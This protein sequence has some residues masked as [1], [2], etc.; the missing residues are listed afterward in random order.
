MYYVYSM[1]VTKRFQLPVSLFAAS[2]AAVLVGAMF[3]TWEMPSAHALPGSSIP[4]AEDA[5]MADGDALVPDHSFESGLASWSL[6]DGYGNAATASCRSALSTTEEWSSDGESSLLIGDERRCHQAGVLSEAVPIESGE[7]YTTWA[8]VHDGSIAWL[9]VHWI[10]ENGDAL[11]EEHSPR[12]ARDDRLEL[13]A[14]APEGA[15]ALRVEIGAIGGLKVDN[16]LLSAQY[17][18]LGSQVTQRPR[19]LSAAAGVDENGRDVLWGMATGSEDDPGILIATDLLTGEVTRTVRLPGATGGWEVTQNPVTGTVY[20]G[21]YG[22]GALWLYTPGDEEAVDAGAPDIPQWDFAYGVAFDE[23][24]NAYGGGW[25]EPTKGY[26]GA[27]VYTFTE[28]EGFTGA[29][30]TVPLTDEANYTRAVG[31]DE[32]SRT[33]FVGT[34]TQVNL[35]GCSIDTNDCED[36][37]G[38]LDEEIQDSVEVREMVVSDGHVLAWVGDGGSTGNDWVVVLKVDRTEAGELQVDVVDEIRGAAYPGSSP[39]VDGHI[40]YTKAGFDGW[41]LFSYDIEAGQETQLPVDA[42]ALVRQWDVVELDDPEWPG[43]TVVGIDSFGTLVRYSIETERI[44]VAMVP[45]FPDVSLRL[46]SLALGPDGS[47]W[48]SGYLNGGIGQ[49]VPMRDDQQGTFP[50]G[51]QAEEMIAHDGRVFQGVYPSGT[52]TSFTP[53]QLQD[54]GA[55]TV[56]CEIGSGQ[57]RPYGMF[58]T[59]D[60]LYFGSQAGAQGN[61]GAFGWVDSVTGECSTLDGPIGEQSIDALTGSNDRIFGGGNIFYGYLHTPVRDE[62]SVMVFDESTE[63]VQEVE[64]DVPGLRAVSAATT[65]ADGTVWFYAEGWLLA[66]DPETLEWVHEEEIFPDLDAGSRIGGS[67]AQMLTTEDGTIYGN[68]GGRVFQVDPADA[69]GGAGASVDVLF[70]GLSA[71]ILTVDELGNLYVRRGATGMLRIVPEG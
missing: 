54:G 37:T 22:R 46:N 53:A 49:Y 12:E 19:L 38:L 4:T 36:L 66:M 8:D 18:A 29:L 26:P 65:A 44:D 56:E 40:Y 17:T 28:G 39:I 20:V 5:V 10:D 25:G 51:G 58:S 57:D 32:A 52:I 60:R 68:A 24:G 15:T 13:Q 41:P 59:E 31:Y 62:A 55:P 61:A 16:V 34:G 14:R 50:V 33:V 9:G 27:S 42:T 11:T 1:D 35:F 3:A 67:Y 2:L 71:G 63:E 7:L 64:L 70:D 47:I 43:A 45:D 23:E 48:S 6:T 69:L 30:G 21:T